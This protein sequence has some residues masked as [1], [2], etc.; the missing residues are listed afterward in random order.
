[1]KLLLLD[2]INNISAVTAFN[3]K[4]NLDRILKKNK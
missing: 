1:M 3:K 4:Y 2:G